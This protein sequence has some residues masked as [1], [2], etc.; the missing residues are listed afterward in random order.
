MSN[1]NRPRK[2]IELLVEL[3]ADFP[4]FGIGFLFSLTREE[5][6]QVEVLVEGVFV[7]IF[8]DLVAGLE[9]NWRAYITGQTNEYSTIVDEIIGI[10]EAPMNAAIRR[11][12]G[13]K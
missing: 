11:I 3:L 13:V 7:G 2:P 12:I 1:G 6:Q 10:A 8:N 4:S 5:K 9:A